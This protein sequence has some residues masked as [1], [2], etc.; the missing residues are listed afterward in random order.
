MPGT[1]IPPAPPSSM[2]HTPPNPI[3]APAR[4]A[5]PGRSATRNQAASIMTS[6]ETAMT[7]AA[8]LVGSSC[9]AAKTRTKNTLTLSSPSTADRPH[10]APR[11][12]RRQRASSTRPAGSARRAAPYSGWSAGRNAWVT[13]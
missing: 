12:R 7:V 9:E 1:L 10:Q 6:G 8:T 5:A 11:G 3:A 4:W 13:K 2:R